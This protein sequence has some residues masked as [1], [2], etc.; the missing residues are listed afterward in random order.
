MD[1]NL[2]VPLFISHDTDVRFMFAGGVAESEHIL[3]SHDDGGDSKKNDVWNGGPW[4]QDGC[5]CGHWRV[6]VKAGRTASGDRTCDTSIGEWLRS[7]RGEPKSALVLRYRARRQRAHHSRGHPPH[8]RVLGQRLWSFFFLSF[9][10]ASKQNFHLA[11]LAR[12]GQAT[13]PRF[14]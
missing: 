12:E 6:D 7:H 9:R 13:G 14:G 11:A 1:G 8:C 10:R 3:V 5:E 2:A 4:R